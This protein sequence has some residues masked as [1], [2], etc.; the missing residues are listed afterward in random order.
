MKII[1]CTFLLMSSIFS[2]GQVKV[3]TM[4]KPQ[5]K[6]KLV[7]SFKLKNF[8]YAIYSQVS[9]GGMDNFDFG[10]NVGETGETYIIYNVTKNGKTKEGYFPKLIRNDSKKISREGSYIITDN[11]LIIT[12]RY[13]DYHFPPKMGISTY[14]PDKFRKLIAVS[15][16]EEDIDPDTLSHD[17]QKRI[18]PTG[19]P[20]ND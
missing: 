7:V 17:Y 12:T 10:Y 13:F 4:P 6:E 3:E 1:I 11:A 19:P 5:S 18:I 8:N 15:Q 2:F 14:K 20:T 9:K 16:K